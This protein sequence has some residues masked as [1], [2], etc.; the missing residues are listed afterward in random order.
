[1][2]SGK[3]ALS[4]R[5]LSVVVVS[6]QVRELLRACLESV[7]AQGDVV[8]E[9]WV[10][11]NASSDGS[12]DMVASRFPEVKLIRSGEN[13]GFGRANNR[14]MRG[15]GESVPARGAHAVELAL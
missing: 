14:V 5:G 10:F 2:P 8:A 3:E 6:Y 7:R 12:A 9:C 13:I 1:M 15:A 4:D 11:D